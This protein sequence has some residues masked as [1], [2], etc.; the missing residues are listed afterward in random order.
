MFSRNYHYLGQLTVDVV[1]GLNR[2]GTIK[3]KGT[4]LIYQDE[5]EFC[6]R[7]AR[8]MK[9]S[10]VACAGASYNALCTDLPLSD[11]FTNCLSDV[12][13]PDLKSINLED[14]C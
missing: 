3:G 2:K 10:I 6:L 4:I 11:N 12:F 14:Y 13:F 8:S 1:M 7:E 9:R 5:L